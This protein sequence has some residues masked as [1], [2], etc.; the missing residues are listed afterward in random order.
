MCLNRRSPFN[1]RSFVKKQRRAGRQPA[2]GALHRTTAFAKEHWIL[3]DWKSL[4]GGFR[5]R[6]PYLNIAD[7]Y[8]RLQDYQRQLP[9]NQGGSRGPSPVGILVTFVPPKVTARRGMSDMPA[10]GTAAGIAQRNTAAAPE[11]QRQRQ[12]A[13]QHNGNAKR[14]AI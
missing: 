11:A 2:D 13:P 1:W 9:A 14:T 6:C 7:T 8:K 10:R 12:R 5:G 4:S 3:K